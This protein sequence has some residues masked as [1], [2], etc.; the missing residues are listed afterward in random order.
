MQLIS[1]FGL[2]GAASLAAAQA[3]N[4]TTGALGDA[5]PVKNNPVIG[6]AWIATFDSPALKG[7]VT[8]VAAKIGINY[9]I[10]V[11][12]LDVAKGPYKYHVHLRPVPVNG[13]CA[14]TLGHL[15]SYVRGDSPPCEKS[16]P[17]TCEVGDLS[18]KYGTV[19]GPDVHYEFNDPYTATNKIQLGYVG[20][21]SIV[22]HDA[23]AARIA[24][25]NLIKKA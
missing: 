7:T 13:T 21:R 9:T 1:F 6:E 17:Q 20:E 5:R 15:D 8:A 25:A 18:G 19:A 11:T 12:G 22:F 23:S 2:L 4:V 10:D 3:T 14:D 16:L 24:C